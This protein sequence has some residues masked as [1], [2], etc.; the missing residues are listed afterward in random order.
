MTHYG[1]HVLKK[2]GDGLMAIFGYPR[3]REND[4]ER[5]ARAALAILAALE[6][7]NVRNEGGSLPVLAARVGLDSG[8]VIVDA[9]GEVF[10]EA[11]TS[12]RA[13]KAPPSP[14][15]RWSPPLC[16]GTLPGCSSPRTGARMI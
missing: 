6:A 5:A 10:G 11:R 16:S 1:G 14:G 9:S 8:P 12:P 15:P 7:L 4:A 2:L 13:C 3:A